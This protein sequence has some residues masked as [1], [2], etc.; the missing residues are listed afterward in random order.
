MSFI[1]VHVRNDVCI[2]NLV[3]DFQFNSIEFQQNVP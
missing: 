3:L 2:N 1:H